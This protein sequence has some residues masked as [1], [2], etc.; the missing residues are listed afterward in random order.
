MENA[1]E[2]RGLTRRFGDRLA[3]DALTLEVPSGTVVGFLGPNGA[4]KTTTVRMLAALVAPTS[5]T[6]VVAG[7]RLGE[8]NDAIRSS[9]GILTESP[10]I[11]ASLTARQNLRFFGRLHGLDDR[12][13]DTRIDE[14]MELL[15]LEGRDRERAGE[16]SKG[17]RQKLAIAR[18][19]LHDPSIV[20]L[21]EPTSALDPESAHTV[22]AFIRDL[23]SQGRTVLLA[24]HN[25]AEADEL[26][27]TIALFRTRLMR[28]DTPANLR[29]A[30]SGRGVRVR[31]AATAAAYAP[32]IAALPFVT[33]VHVAAIAPGAGAGTPG[34]E[35]DTLSVELA[36]PP[37][38]TPELVRAIVEAG[39]PVLAIEPLA[40]SLEEVYLQLMADAATSETS[41]VNSVRG[42]A[43]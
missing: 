36:D 13:I 7:H 1:I 22:R 37:V 3:V 17:M 8:D 15:G 31:L 11:Y 23:R 21:D 29:A 9:I 18:A 19:L 28:L 30:V 40:S 20:F 6:A 34:V 4:G 26:C 5:G 27:D 10:G 25:L 32:A 38:N 33:G 43:A 16:Y 24:T 41:A 35:S 14:Y 39:A 42:E 2:T 12:L